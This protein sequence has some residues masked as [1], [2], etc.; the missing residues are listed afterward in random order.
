MISINIYATLY[1]G[2]KLPAKYVPNS[3]AVTAQFSQ[4]R[5]YCLNKDDVITERELGLPT[6]TQDKHGQRSHY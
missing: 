1:G 2:M 4:E 3:E 5:V 6:N